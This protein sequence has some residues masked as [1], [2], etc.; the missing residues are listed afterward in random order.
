M[1][2]NTEIQKTDLAQWAETAKYRKEN[3]KWLRYSSKIALRIL[4][5]IEDIPDM[6]QKKLAELA[7]VS[8]QHISKVV[9]GQENLTLKSI[10]RLSEILCKELIE[11]PSYKYNEKRSYNL[12]FVA[13][14]LFIDIPISISTSNKMEYIQQEN[15]W[16]VH[17]S[18]STEYNNIQTIEL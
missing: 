15:G 11:F 13:V 6:N 17:R 2:N 1:N 18:V 5:A 8:P 14:Q 3:K 16:S 7:E 9:K 10:A 4:A 12:T